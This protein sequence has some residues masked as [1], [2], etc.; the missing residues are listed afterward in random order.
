VIHL[1]F[2][3]SKNWIAGSSPAM[4]MGNYFASFKNVTASMRLPSQSRMK[5]A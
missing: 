4:T 3:A 2:S 5:A 1:A